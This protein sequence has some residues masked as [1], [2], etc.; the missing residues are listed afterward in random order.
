[1]ETSS[2]L[3]DVRNGIGWI[4][5]NRPRTLNSLNL[6]IATAIKEHLEAWKTNPDVAL[7]CVLGAGDKG[8]CAGGDIRDLYDHRASNI[9]EHA[10]AFFTTEY[11]MDHAFWDFPK[12]ILVYMDGIV[13]GGGVGL[14]VGATHRIVTERTKWAMPEM[15]I[16]FFPDVGSSYFLNQLPGA[17]GRYLA[18]TSAVLTPE[19]VLYLGFADYYLEKKHWEG[20]E[21][22]LRD[23]YW[24]VGN[25][26]RDLNEL[27]AKYCKTTYENSTLKELQD[28]INDHF[29]FDTVEEIVF[30]LEQASEKGDGWA[31][32]TKNELLAKSPTSLKV[33]LKQLQ[34]GKG[35]SYVDCLRM[36][37][38][39]AMNFMTHHD[40]YEGVRS[41]LVDKDKNPRW[42]PESLEEVSTETVSSFFRYEW[43]E[44]KHPLKEIGEEARIHNS[45]RE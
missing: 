12:P 1:M 22:A 30:S 29:S 10:S 42:D 45:W 6:E 18:L 9:K 20:L 8:L 17:V 38:N 21:Q 31:G 3:F 14:S 13:M 2:V 26:I 5:L 4:K 28:K 19:D 23:K 44:Q 43:P 27:L 37:L 36:E 15:N 11:L 7:I 35:Q 16:G 39:I 25:A 32:K 24:T 41:M 34:E 40:F 33:A